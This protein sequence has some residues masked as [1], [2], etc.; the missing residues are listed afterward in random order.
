MSNAHAQDAHAQSQGQGDPRAAALAKA[1]HVEERMAALGHHLV[2]ESGLIATAATQAD[3]EYIRQAKDSIHTSLD[4][5]TD[6]LD[7]LQS[8]IEQMPP[9]ASATA[10][11]HI[12][13]EDGEG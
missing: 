8:Q 9:E 4:H 1:N 12:H 10:N 13:K 11:N 3:H 2:K 6:L 7:Q 5:T